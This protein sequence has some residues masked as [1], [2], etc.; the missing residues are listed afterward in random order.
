MHR[1]LVA[2]VALLAVFLTPIDA[3]W[4]AYTCAADDD[5]TRP[6]ATAAARSAS[7]SQDLPGAATAIVAHDDCAAD[8]TNA[9]IL[10]ALQGRVSHI[11]SQ[12]ASPIIGPVLPSPRPAFA[13]FPTWVALS[14]GSPLSAFS[15]ALRI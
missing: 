15:C 8:L 9:A 12:V 13:T 6:A 11:A 2:T 5:A 10:A 1:R 7:C 4:C 14:R 3:L